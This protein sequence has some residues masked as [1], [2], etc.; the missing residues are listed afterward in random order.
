MRFYEVSDQSKSRQKDMCFHAMQ[1][2]ATCSSCALIVVC[3]WSPPLGKRGIPAQTFHSTD[4]QKKFPLQLI[5]THT[6]GLFKANSCLMYYGKQ[7]NKISTSLAIWMHIVTVNRMLVSCWLMQNY[8]AFKVQSSKFF[9]CPSRVNIVCIWKITHRDNFK[10]DYSVS[11]FL[12][13]LQ[14]TWISPPKI[15]TSQRVFEL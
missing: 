2:C 13:F 3:E 11:V 6:Q 9:Y 4:F 12:Q 1:G 8:T 15:Y 14:T 10:W 7:R 5:H